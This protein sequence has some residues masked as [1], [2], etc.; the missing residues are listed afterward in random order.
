MTEI[1]RFGDSALLINFEQKI[2]ILINEKVIALG[3]KIQSGFHSEIKFI[4]PAYCSLAVGFDSNKISFD[5]LSQMIKRLSENIH[6]NE[7]LSKSF[8]KL[9]IPVCYK[10]PYSIDFQE[11]NNQIQLTE[12]EIIH[13]H[14]STEFRV[15]MLGFLP[16]FPYMGKLPK[17]LFCQRKKTPRLKVPKNSVG[18]AGSQTGIYPSEAPGGW[19]IIGRTPIPVF[20]TRSENPFLF[21]A[22]DSVRFYSISESDF[23]N[24]EKDVRKGNFKKESLY[25]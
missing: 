5:A 17:A 14:T 16:G 22:G 11:L 24:I 9:K 12:K 13:L 1:Q 18:L 20:D 7:N 10:L 19:Q 3:K 15:F 6:N 25:E 21:R 8:R 4:T 2:D 23:M